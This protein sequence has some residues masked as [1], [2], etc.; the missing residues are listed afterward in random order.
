LQKTK[1]PALGWELD[2]YFNEKLPGALE[3]ADQGPQPFCRGRR[4]QLG[5]E[6]GGELVEE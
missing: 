5:V 2:M 1:N 6:A 4:E 3:I